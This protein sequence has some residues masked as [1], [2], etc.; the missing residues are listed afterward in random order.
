MTTRGVVDVPSPLGTDSRTY[1]GR[2]DRP[3]IEA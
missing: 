1:L 2:L 3:G